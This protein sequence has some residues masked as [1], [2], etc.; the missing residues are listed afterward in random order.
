MSMLYLSNVTTLEVRDVIEGLV[1]LDVAGH[2]DQEGW[3][4]LRLKDKLEKD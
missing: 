4:C 3:I 1:R 2:V